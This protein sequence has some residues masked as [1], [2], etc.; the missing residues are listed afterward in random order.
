MLQA[1]TANDVARL[2]WYINDEFYKS[3]APGEK[4]FF[5]PKAGQVKISCTDDKGRNRDIY[6]RVRL[7]NL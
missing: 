1:R 4:Q 2:Y 3:T 5:V 6:I 7:V